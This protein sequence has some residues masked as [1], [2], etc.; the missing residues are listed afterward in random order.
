MTS[1]NE[2]VRAFLLQRG[3][4]V[5]EIDGAEQEDRLHLLV[6]DS[7]LLS[8]ST[9]YTALDVANATGM[10]IEDTRRLWRAMGFP[11]VAN[12][13][14]IFTDADIETLT[15]VQ[16]LL[17]LRLIEIDT[18]VELT[19]VIGSSMARIAEAEVAIAPVGRGPVALSSAELAELWALTAEETV[20][21]LARVLEYVWRRHL[22]AAARRALL[23]PADADHGGEEVAVGFAD[24][25]GFTSLSQQ[26]SEAALGEVVGRFES[27]AH[28]TVTAAGGR[29][30]KMIGDAAMFV[31]ADPAAA[32]EIGLTMADIYAA[33]EVV[34]A[35]R[36]GIAYG[37]ALAR[38]GDY[39]GPVV[40]RAS[41]IQNVAIA[42]TVVV[43]DE[44]HAVLG[45][46]P[47]F[48]W[49][50]L[51]TRYLKDIGRVPLWAA[52]RP[53]PQ[54]RR[55]EGRRRPLLTLISEAGR[56]AIEQAIDR[57]LGLAEQADAD[58]TR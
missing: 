49:R 33:D 31:V 23:R 20:P 11:D 8:G 57:R 34:S 19:R 39:F 52:H 10:D 56:E 27:V 18:A 6:I 47:R 14:A 36:V 4:G 35:V 32:V 38:E 43:D 13:A 21:S 54:E 25:V 58:E 30:V 22:Q 40:N 24:L 1:P 55:E 17:A 48:A 26:L 16:G 37:R 3:I 41:R 15:T 28:D 2:R 51:R 42:G 44:V 29:I 50:S 7:I 12:D 5:E 46:D 9:R 53:E 45:A